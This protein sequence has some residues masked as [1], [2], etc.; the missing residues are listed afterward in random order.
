MTFCFEILNEITSW[1]VRD[2]GQLGKR[3][4]PVIFW[5]IRFVL[6]GVEI[7]FGFFSGEPCGT[8][9]YREEGDFA[10]VFF[11]FFFSGGF[12]SFFSMF[13]FLVFL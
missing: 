1:E 4:L 12:L 11:L 13:V 3:G 2:R 9:C 10:R 7:V 5:R 8:T 6:E